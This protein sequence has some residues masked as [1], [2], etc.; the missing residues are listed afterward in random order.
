MS[1]ETI[2]KRIKIIQD[3]A[4]EVR[5]ATNA[6]KDNINDLPA[7]QELQKREESLKEE[8]QALREKAEAAKSSGTVKAMVDELK[9]L[10]DDLKANKDALAQELVEYYKET[11]SMSVT[12]TDGTVYHIVFA[13]KLT[14]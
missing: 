12:D 5:K 10:K 7:V 11:G 9:E 1:L 2:K 14:N 3:M 13:A 8:I 6:Y 4:A